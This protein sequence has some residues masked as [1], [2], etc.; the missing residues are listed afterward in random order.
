MAH[1]SISDEQLAA[2]C[3][4]HRIRK[5]SLFESVRKGTAGP[6]SDIDWLVECQPR[7]TSATTLTPSGSGRP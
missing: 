7:C 6:E 4:K 3:R 5:L 2:F 1:L